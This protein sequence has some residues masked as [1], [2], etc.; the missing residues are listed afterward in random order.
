MP[1]G[2]GGPFNRRVDRVTR[3]SAQRIQPI[4]RL[5]ERRINLQRPPE[6]RSRFFQIGRVAQVSGAEIVS[7]D[8]GLS[9]TWA[10]VSLEQHAEP[11]HRTERD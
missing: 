6:R 10:G 5:L 1:S 8:K 11:I 2:A 4:S 9:G 3:P 7:Q